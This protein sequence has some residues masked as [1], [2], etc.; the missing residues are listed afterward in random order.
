MKEAILALL[1]I[2][3][4][5]GSLWAVSAFEKGIL[6]VINR[7]MLIIALGSLIAILVLIGTL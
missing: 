4:L 2:L 6:R 3:L 1:M 7:I 5:S